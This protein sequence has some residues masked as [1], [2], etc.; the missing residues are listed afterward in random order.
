[1]TMENTIQALSIPIN[2][3]RFGAIESVCY[4]KVAFLTI[5][6]CGVIGI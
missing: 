2:Y 6:V 1:M 3:L 4:A 5:T